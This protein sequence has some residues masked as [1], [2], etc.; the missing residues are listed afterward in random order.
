MSGI[1]VSRNWNGPG[2]TLPEVYFNAYLN[3]DSTSS[4]DAKNFTPDLISICLGTND[5]SDGDGKQARAALDQDTFVSSYVN[6]VKRI[7]NRYP[8]AQICC[9]TSPAISS[10]KGAKLADY[11]SKVIRHFQEVE[12]DKKIHMFVF[13]HNYNHGC[14]GHPDKEEHE[15]LAKELLPFFKKVMD[16]E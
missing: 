13:P 5:F 2:P 8:N 6:F 16:W 3:A 10:E 4:W 15:K 9:L 12:N 7:R 1:G 14:T 11:L